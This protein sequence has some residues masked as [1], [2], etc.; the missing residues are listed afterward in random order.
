MPH[1]AITR[2]TTKQTVN[3]SKTPKSHTA[4]FNVSVLASAG[5]LAGYRVMVTS[6]SKTQDIH[7][8]MMKGIFNS[9]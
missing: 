5:W 9:Q 7:V 8:Y 3:V 4:H 1:S 6:H 2:N